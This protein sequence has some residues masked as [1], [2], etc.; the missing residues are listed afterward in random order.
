MTK[1]GLSYKHY[2][3]LISSFFVLLHD[4]FLSLIKL[5]FFLALV[6]VTLTV[7]SF[8]YPFYMTFRCLCGRDINENGELSPTLTMRG[9][10]FFHALMG[11]LYEENETEENQQ[12]SSLKNL[13][14]VIFTQQ[15]RQ[16]F[17]SN[18]N[19]VS[20][21]RADE[22]KRD[23]E[24]ELTEGGVRARK[25]T[26]ESDMVCAICM[27]EFVDEEVYI[28]LKC[29]KAHIFHEKCIRDWLGIKQS[30]PIC[31]Q[32][33]RAEAYEKTFEQSSFANSF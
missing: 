18:R 23:R 11:P 5:F 19:V 28:N 26:T 31:R 30:C 24:I 16:T 9:R 12:E 17:R 1:D 20:D 4:F 27:C 7:L 25:K 22:E 8:L 10:S 6:L 15:N 3:I 13:F 21:V 29:A 33:V 14:A 32:E 2:L